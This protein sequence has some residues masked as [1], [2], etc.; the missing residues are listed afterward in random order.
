MSEKLPEW[1]LWVGIMLCSSY[2]VALVAD[3]VVE[4]KSPIE[5]VCVEGER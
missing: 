1:L 5:C 3:A 4:A 2:L